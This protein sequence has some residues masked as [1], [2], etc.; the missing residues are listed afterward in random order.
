MKTKINFTGCITLSEAGRLGFSEEAK[1]AFVITDAVVDLLLADGT[2]MTVPLP[3]GAAKIAEKGR[4]GGTPTRNVYRDWR[5][6]I[7]VE[8]DY[9]PTQGAVTPTA[10]KIAP[11][12]FRQAMKVSL[13]KG[14]GGKV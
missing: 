1:G 3:L 2:V 8:A 9:T 7:D 14:K 10:A 4:N 12:D 5:V 13:V 6:D 11:V